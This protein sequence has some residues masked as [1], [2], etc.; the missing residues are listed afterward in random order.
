MMGDSQTRQQRWAADRVLD[1][2]RQVDQHKSDPVPLHAAMARALMTGLTWEQIVD[3][4]GV[5]KWR[6]G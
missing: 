5:G 3:L 2:A 1:A 4:F 6:V